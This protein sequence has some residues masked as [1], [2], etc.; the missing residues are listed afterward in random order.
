MGCNLLE[1][2][3][4]RETE[5]DRKNILVKLLHCTAAT[6]HLGT[7]ILIF[8][9]QNIFCAVQMIVSFIFYGFSFLQKVESTFENKLEENKTKTTHLHDIT[10]P[11]NF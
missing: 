11:F 2:K 4:R 1:N 5:K 7:L 9:E 8:H 6:K 10:M 3:C